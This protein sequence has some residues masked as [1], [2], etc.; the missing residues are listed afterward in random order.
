MQI[1]VL[2]MNYFERVKNTY[3]TNSFLIENFKIKIK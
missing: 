2:Y 1:K 3:L